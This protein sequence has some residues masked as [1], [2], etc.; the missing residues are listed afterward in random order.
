MHFITPSSVAEL[1]ITVT[2]TA[3][4][5]I[6]LMETAGSKEQLLKYYAENGA[7][8]VLII[9]EDG[10]IRYLPGVNPTTAIGVPI[11]SGVKHRLPNIDISALRLISQS[12]NVSCQVVFYRSDMGANPTS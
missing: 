10:D 4:N 1:N 9:P 5:L 3:T 6:D 11:S 2:T 12:G 8:S 7:N